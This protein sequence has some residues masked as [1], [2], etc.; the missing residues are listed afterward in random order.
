MRSI[1]G[2]AAALIGLAF[3]LEHAAN[4]GTINFD[5]VPS[6]TVIDGQYASQQVT[7]S[8][9]P[10]RLH[11]NDGHV[12]ARA[13]GYARSGPNS[14]GLGNSPFAYVND[15]DGYIDVHFNQL[16]GTVSVDVAAIVVSEF[17]TAGTL[18]PYMMAYGA[19]D[20][21]TGKNPWLASVYYPSSLISGLGTTTPGAWQTLT[22]TRPTND[23]QFVILSAP[24]VYPASPNAYGEF[25][26]LRFGL[27]RP[28][29][30]IS[31]LR[32]PATA[33]AGQ[34][35]AVT[36]TTTNLGTAWSSASVTNLYWSSTPSFTAA[37]VLA[38][39]HTV[40]GLAPGASS[41]PLT[42]SIIIPPG[43]AG[44][45]Y[46]L[47]VADGGSWMTESN[48]ANNT[49]ATRV[50]VGP[51]PDLIVSSLGVST[52][53]LLGAMSISYTVRNT[54]TV[55]AKAFRV[56]FSRVQLRISRL[57][58]KPF[59]CR[60]VAELAARAQFAETVRV[61]RPLAPPG[62]LTLQTIE[63]IADADAVIDEL[64]ETNNT[65]SVRVQL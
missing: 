41:G 45:H 8:A 14:I 44:G 59:L 49:R 58:V 9:L 16:Q 24:N 36:D 60:Q 38:G 40:P 50:F 17:A 32:A 23:I 62:E 12:Y 5:D 18:P 6:G 22:I 26:N 19:K 3:A 4:A 56:C 55:A 31:A 61:T 33:T 46:V 25:D 63:A 21:A 39:S 65:R 48:E 37:A 54:G 47:A 1:N 20:P 15:S 52:G 2:C 13:D 11:T 30:T 29:L 28:D 7:F 57:P 35:V 53:P 27:S 43:T 34:V 64:D 10:G 42:T 51:G